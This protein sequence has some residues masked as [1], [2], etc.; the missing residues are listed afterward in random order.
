MTELTS[1]LRPPS[2]R[3]IKVY[4]ARG[5]VEYERARSRSRL[6]RWLKLILPGVAIL[7]IVGFVTV[8]KL[9][10]RFDGF[11]MSGLNLD[12]KS[13]TIDKPRFSG[14]KGTAQSYEIAAARA[15][16][17]LAN[18]NVVR[19]EEIAGTFGVNA[20]GTATLAAKAGV[21]DSTRQSLILKDG[22]SVKTTDGVT[23][24]LGEAAV[25]FEKKT[26]VSETPVVITN[27][28]GELHASGVTM[29]DGGGTIRFKNVSITYAPKAG[30]G[31]A[32]TP[33]AEAVK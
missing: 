1:D 12:T 18:P 3:T 6:V 21:Y 22:V 14:F 10:P 29:Q 20:D 31:I 7:G 28:E 15:I 17:D 19:L 27:A 30:D 24:S 25:D 5:E 26:L 23:I 9:M 16:Q 2:R 8:Y 32:A 11:S 33:K 13:L 4:A